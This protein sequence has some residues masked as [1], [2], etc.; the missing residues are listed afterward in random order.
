MDV[1]LQTNFY[2]MNLMAEIAA[3]KLFEILFSDKRL[4]GGNLQK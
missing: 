2:T 3:I 4:K 1:E